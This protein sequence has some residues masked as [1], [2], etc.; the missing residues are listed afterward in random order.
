MK[1]KKFSFAILIAIFAAVMPSASA[2]DIPLLTWER[3]KQQNIILGGP[4]TGNGWK[5][6]FVAEGQAD[7]ELSASLPNSAGFIVYSIDIPKE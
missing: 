5:I 3:G 7:R 1:S 2:V 6:F 4:S